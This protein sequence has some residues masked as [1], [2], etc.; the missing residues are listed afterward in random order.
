MTDETIPQMRETIDRLAKDNKSL[1]AENE[2][3]K[4]DN[5]QLSAREVAR[6]A[7]LDPKIGELF[8]KTSDD[9]LTAEGLTT[10]AT[11]LG[12]PAVLDESPNPEGG[13]PA[14]DA[15]GSAPDAKGSADLSK[16]SRGG[17]TD[18]EGAGGADEETMT[19]AEWTELSR[20]DPDA[21]RVA[22]AKGKVQI[23]RDNPFLGDTQRPGNPFAEFQQ[24]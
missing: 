15:E 13:E 8:A 17:S 10:F 3:L 22:L 18:S 14:E 23:S 19:R 24:R 12:L 21:A 16:M 7:K 1:T 6:E 11:D 5:R 20:T 2:T 9:D 4:G